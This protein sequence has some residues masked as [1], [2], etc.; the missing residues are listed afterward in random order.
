MLA[1]V[2]LK[3]AIQRKEVQNLQIKKNTL[4]YY[5]FEGIFKSFSKK[6]LK[7]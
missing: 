3:E 7:K 1:G 4:M 5:F 6:K 2:S